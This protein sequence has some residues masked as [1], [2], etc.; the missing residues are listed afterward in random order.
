MKLIFGFQDVIEIVNNGVEALPENPT[1][2]QRNGHR[3][4]KKKDCKT[5]FYIHE[6]VDNKVFEKIAYAESSKKAWDTLVKYINGADKMKKIWLQSLRRQY[7][8]LQMK[9]E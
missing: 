1:D 7:E 4:A 2:V 5:L 3:E 9:K 6:C 8:L